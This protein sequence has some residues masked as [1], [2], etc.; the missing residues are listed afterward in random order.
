MTKQSLLSRSRKKRRKPGPPAT[1]KGTL[2][3]VR[4]QPPE[5]TALDEWIA[6][7]DDGLSRPE[8]IRRLMVASL[9]WTDPADAEAIARSLDERE[10]R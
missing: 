1:G 7:R 8:A 10:E 4:L 5:L 3:G 2:V 9:R 6:A